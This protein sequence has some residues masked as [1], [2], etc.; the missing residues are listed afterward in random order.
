MEFFFFHVKLYE[1]YI[2]VNFAD[3]LPFLS[4]KKD[5]I[6]VHALVFKNTAL[7]LLG[8]NLAALFTA[9]LVPCVFV[10]PG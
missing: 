8:R 4:F 7:T 6:L 5:I 2:L 3:Y 9:F 10:F 1:L